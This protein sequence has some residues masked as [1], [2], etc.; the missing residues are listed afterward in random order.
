MTT[1]DG[2]TLACARCGA[3]F[4][5]GIDDAA[6]CWCARLPPLPAAALAADGDCLCERCLRAALAGEQQQDDKQGGGTG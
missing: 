1:S 6:G 5:C 3:P 4:R 2:R